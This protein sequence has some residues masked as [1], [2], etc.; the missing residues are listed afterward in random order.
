[1]RFW[2]AEEGEAAMRL[3]TLRQPGYQVR[4][5]AWHERLLREGISAGR[6]DL[7]ADPHEVA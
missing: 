3:L 5:V 1:M 6:L 4:L 7:S 2:L